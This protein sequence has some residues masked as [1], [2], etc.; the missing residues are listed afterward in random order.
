MGQTLRK[1]KQPKKG[2]RST[3]GQQACAKALAITRRRGNG[4]QSVL[5]K[6]DKLSV[7]FEN[8]RNY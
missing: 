4:E 7:F 2:Q 5:S 6:V 3:N 8:K 1:H